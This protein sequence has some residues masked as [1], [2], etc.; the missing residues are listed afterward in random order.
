MAEMVTETRWC[1][2]GGDLCG[3]SAQLTFGEN[4]AFCLLRKRRNILHKKE[5]SVITTVDRK[6]REGNGIS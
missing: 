5:K 1:V 2:A 6:P 4:V 3:S